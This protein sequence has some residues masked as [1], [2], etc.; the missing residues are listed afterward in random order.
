MVVATNIQCSTVTQDTIP[1]PVRTLILLSPGHVIALPRESICLGRSGSALLQPVS[2]QP[3]MELQH[4]TKVVSTVE[5]G[6]KV[7]TRFCV[8][9]EGQ[10]TYQ[11]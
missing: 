6:H 7:M 10:L 11:T 2:C 4:Q 3:V 5:Q 9:S 1:Q 8:T